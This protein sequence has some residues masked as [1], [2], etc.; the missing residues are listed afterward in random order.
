M[1][2]YNIK[3]SIDKINILIQAIDEI[4]TKYGRGLQ[5]II[6]SQLREQ[7][8]PFGD[9]VIKNKKPEAENG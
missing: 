8:A 1:K 3:L 9:Q 4:P 2:E 6:E 5:N 7:K